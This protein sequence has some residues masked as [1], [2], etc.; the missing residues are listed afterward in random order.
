MMTTSKHL[1]VAVVAGAGAVVA[2]HLYKK[3]MASRREASSLKL[4]AEESAADELTGQ[5]RTYPMMVLRIEDALSLDALP[6]HEEVR[7]LLVEWKPNMGHVIFFSHTWLGYKHPDPHG[8][9]WRLAKDLLKTALAGK[10]V[11][12]PHWSIEFIFGK[13]RIPAAELQQ[14]LQGGYVWVD[15]ASVPQED[16]AAQGK[17]I[18]P[19]APTSM[20]VPSSSAWRG[21]GHTPT[22]V[23]PSVTC[24][25]GLT[26]DGAASRIWQT[27]CRFLASAT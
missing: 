14:K 21:R 23:A 7:D 17:A 13:L 12:E 25:R 20:T 1:T 27:R 6:K 3:F 2:V 16:K 8:V 18:A 4:L 5:Q 22:M 10:L 24:A 11:I 15:F 19:L 26:V 9:K